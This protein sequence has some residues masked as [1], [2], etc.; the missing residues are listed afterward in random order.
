LIN[1]FK[2]IKED[3]FV[4]YSRDPAIHS[5]FEIFFN[6]PGVWAVVLHRV[7]HFF[8]TRGFKRTARFISAITR[9]LCF[10]DIHPAAKI[11]RRLFIDHGLGVVIGETAI[12]GDDV[13]IYQQVTL[14][15]VEL[16]PN[17]RHPTIK[18]GV[19]IGAGAKVLGNITVGENVKIG[20][21]SVVVKDV[22]D[23]TT[24]VG[25]PARNIIKGR[26]A[27]SLLSHNKLPDIDKELFAYLVKRITVLEKALIFGNKDFIK[28]DE[29]LDKIYENFIKAIEVKNG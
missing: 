14:G 22:P 23:N 2:L 4:P 16:T 20:A 8:Y 10:I 13:T 21:N 5:R 6:Y 18:N 3:F 27:T 7:A 11:G 12:V 9:F 28:E 15:G 25:I 24:A 1:V 17:K 26:A 29:E 19:V